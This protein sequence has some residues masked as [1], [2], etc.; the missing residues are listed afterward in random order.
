MRLLDIPTVLDARGEVTELAGLRLVRLVAGREAR[1]PSGEEVQ[2]LADV[3][4][5]QLRRAEPLET[6]GDPLVVGEVEEL[7]RV[8]DVLALDGDAR[9][10]GRQ[11]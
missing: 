2:S 6:D 11:R 5:G 9:L 1:D 7:R 3:R 8:L 10:A 4:T